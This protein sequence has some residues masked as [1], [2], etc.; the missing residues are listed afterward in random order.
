VRTHRP[1]FP[2]SHTWPDVPDAHF[3]DEEGEYEAPGGFSGSPSPEWT[4]VVLDG[5]TISRLYAFVENPD[6]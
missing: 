2:P 1:H 4:F 5:D 6:E 3:Q